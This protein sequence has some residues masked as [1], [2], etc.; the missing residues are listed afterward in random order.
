MEEVLHQ[1]EQS[2]KEYD[3]LGAADLYEKALK[4]LPED[5]YSKKGEIHERRGYAFYQASFQAESQ[6]EFKNR[7]RQSAGDYE[8]AVESYGKMQGTIPGNLRCQAMIA[9]ANYWLAGEV[10]DRKRFLDECWRKENEVLKVYEQAKDE[11][12]YGKTCI[13][14][15][16]CL[17]DR[18]DLELDRQVRE[19]ILDEAVKVGE[20]AIQIFSRPGYEHELARAYCF[21]SIHCDNAAMSLQL[22]AK[23]KE[24]ERKAFDYAKQAIKVSES[25]YDKLL[26]GRSI[27]WLALAELDLGAGYEIASELFKKALRYCNEKKDHRILSEEFDGLAFCYTFGMFPEE[28]LEKVRED[29]RKTEEYAGEAIRCSVLVN[30]GSGVPHSF[31]MGYSWN[32]AELARRE[33]ELGT[34]YKLLKNAVALGKKG[35]EHAKRTGSTHA[36]LHGSWMLAQALCD[37][38]TMETGTEKRQL[39]EDAMTIGEKAVYYTEQLRPHYM[40]PQSFPYA[41]LATTLLELSKLEEKGERR[42]E[43][44]EKSVSRMETCVALLQRHIASFPSRRELFA[45]LGSFQAGLG[46]ILNQ[47]YEATAEKEALRKQIEAYQ[48]AVQ[49]NQKADLRSRAAEAYWQ[50]AVAYDHLGEYLESANNFE[51]ASKQY[52]LS[53]HN[54]PQ[55]G[56]FYTDYAMYMQAWNEI[57][58]ARQHHERQEY[59]S[60]RAHFEKAAELHKSLKQW[61]YLAS[62]YAAW[63]QI[64]YAEELSRKEQ[65]E[66]ALQ[67]F[68]EAISLFNE[69]KESVQNQVTKIEN[70]DEKQ[71]TNN[72]LE[73][74]DIR[75]EYCAARIALEDAKI[76]EKKGDHYL[77]SQKYGSAAEAFNKVEQALESD[78][79]RKEV[80]FI[81]SLSEAWQK[82]ML[83]DARASPELYM[84]ASELFEQASKESYTEATGLQTLG[85]SRFCRALEAG[86]RFADTRDRNMHAKAQQFLESA[87]NY[88]AK[89]GFQ[90]ASDYVKATE[91]LFDAYVCMDNAKKEEDPEKKAKLCVVAEKVLQTAAGSFMKAE[92][93]EKRGQVLR[94]LEQ[95]KEERELAVS[96]SEVLH[97]PSIVSATTS[98]VAPAPTSEEAVGSERFEQADI[99]ANL[100]VRQ[101][102]LKIGE[103]LSLE[104]ELVNA[105]KGPALLVKVNKV[106]PEGFE[107]KEKPETYRVEDSYIDM[108]GKRLGPLKTEELRLILKPKIQG[109]FTLK[110]TILYLDENGKYK[111]HEP[112]P[113]TIV[114]KEL[115]IK[116]WIKGER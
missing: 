70:A 112:E 102:E 37:L 25:T 15:T 42:K 51:S 72:I 89:A 4:L 86:T 97:V 1:A 79:E 71:M 104:M 14:L 58:K 34:R 35:L 99:Q 77:A 22:E 33:I 28:K 11:L 115:G 85:H 94:L 43:L 9:Y 105:G 46:N 48:G 113:V 39:L 80:G 24:S 13:E 84:E 106:I 19:K 65:S 91:L 114:V 50:I 18:L 103:P 20:K 73:A 12:G 59:G 21:T 64:E 87:A 61:R 63:A 54:I 96:I 53:A 107:L 47:L 116:G 68:K 23:R 17:N 109:T 95:V 66:E 26:L 93:P 60:A 5:D 31:S 110:P 45:E 92:H 57:E 55:L 29:S 16:E 81:K 40:L 49:M 108:K 36:I 41:A 38:S 8:G 69:T 67:A 101:K 82:M 27:V 83:A 30:Y 56:S 32:F 2:E 44:L 75:R 74:T 10:P 88:Y 52:E 62:N 78:R 98:F 3:W 90:K 76:L 6:E 7:M 100:I 111:S